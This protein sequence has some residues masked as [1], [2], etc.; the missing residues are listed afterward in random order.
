MWTLS[1]MLHTIRKQLWVDKLCPS[2][3][4][5]AGAHC[6]GW[7][8][9]THWRSLGGMCNGIVN[10]FHMCTLLFIWVYCFYKRVVVSGRV[11]DV[12]LQHQCSS[13][14]SFLLA[15]MTMVGSQLVEEVDLRM[16]LTGATS[17]LTLL[18]CMCRRYSL[19]TFV[20]KFFCSKYINLWYYEIMMKA[21]V[22]L[23]I[24]MASGL[25]TRDT[26][27]YL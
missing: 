27:T 19:V 10:A 6:M 4:R 5:I 9:C 21:N 24:Y 11:I 18:S 26:S 3:S 2:E 7:N 14:S 16:N 22:M 20:K 23:V 25:A 12:C 17:F 8:Y 15:W 1:C 13:F